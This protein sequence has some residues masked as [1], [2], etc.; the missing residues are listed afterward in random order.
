MNNA[1]AQLKNCFPDFYYLPYTNGK[2]ET[3]QIGVTVSAISYREAMMELY[4]YFDDDTQQHIV[5]MRIKEGVPKTYFGIPAAAQNTPFANAIRKVYDD[6]ASEFNSIKGGQI[7]TGEVFNPSYWYEVNFAIPGAAYSYV[8]LGSTMGVEPKQCIAQFFLG[9]KDLAAETYAKFSQI[10]FES[11]GPEFIYSY[12]KPMEILTS[13]IPENAENVMIF[14]IKKERMGEA[15]VPVIA[16]INQPQADGR[17]LIYLD[18]YE[19]MY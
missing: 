9:D 11:L 12:D 2:M 1:A 7:Q 13:V 6:V 5:E 3:I 10:I 16:L 18:F 17:Y 8:Y 14:A 4:T 19:A 15:K